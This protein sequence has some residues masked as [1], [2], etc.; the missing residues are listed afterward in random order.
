[1]RSAVESYDSP[2]MNLSELDVNGVGNVVLLQEDLDV[3]CRIVGS[4]G[5]R[6]PGDDANVHGQ[7]TDIV[8]PPN[9]LE[10]DDV[11]ALEDNLE[12]PVSWCHIT[13]DAYRLA[14]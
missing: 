5:R 7:R 14:A 12:C 2:L 11:Q 13:L 4:R 9:R 1:M 6:G 3:L 8:C 10:A